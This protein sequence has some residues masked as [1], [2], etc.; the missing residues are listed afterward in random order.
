MAPGARSKFGAPM[1]EPE[2]F[3]KQIYCIELWHFWDFSAPPEWFGAPYWLGAGNCGPLAPLPRYAPGVKTVNKFIKRLVFGR[4]PPYRLHFVLSITCAT[5]FRASVYGKYVKV[6]LCSEARSCRQH[7]NSGFISSLFLFRLSS[8]SVS[9]VHISEQLTKW[10]L[11][12]TVATPLLRPLSTPGA[13]RT[14]SCLQRSC[15]ILVYQAPTFFR[16]NSYWCIFVR[17]LLVLCNRNLHIARWWSLA[18]RK[19]R[20]LSDT[21]VQRWLEQVSWS[22]RYRQLAQRFSTP[23][24]HVH[25]AR[26]EKSVHMH[27]VVAAQLPGK[28]SIII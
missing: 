6:W 1:F 3:R 17:G 22:N 27:S 28:L 4:D 26:L 8:H 13:L 25:I 19:F 21:N 20:T 14:R 24:A 2:L 7:I 12:W 9:S 15:Y 23:G 18:G 5:D 16:R 11:F 10:Q